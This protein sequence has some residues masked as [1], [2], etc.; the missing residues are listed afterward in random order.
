MTQVWPRLG[1]APVP[2]TVSVIFRPEGVVTVLPTWVPTWAPTWADA[3][4]GRLAVSAAARAI[5]IAAC[6][7]TCIVILLE[8]N[9]QIKPARTARTALRSCAGAPCDSPRSSDGRLRC[10]R[11]RSGLRHQLE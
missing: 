6:G 7:K 10:G 4:V 9:R 1:A 11:T 5:A 2:T 3:A 8:L